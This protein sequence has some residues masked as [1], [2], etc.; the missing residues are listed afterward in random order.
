MKKSVTNIY[1]LLHHSRYTKSA[2][3]K[4]GMH[5]F[6]KYIRARS[7]TLCRFH[8]EDPQIFGG[9]IYNLIA[10]DVSTLHFKVFVTASSL[11][12]HCTMYEMFVSLK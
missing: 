10:W 9:T 7:A 2:E 6:S 11:V 1:E 4:A 3:F 8:T 5:K 12:Q